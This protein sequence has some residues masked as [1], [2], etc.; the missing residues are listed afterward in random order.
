LGR[1][2]IVTA[3]LGAT[4][5]ALA[6]VAMS[7]ASI[8]SA[9]LRSPEK[10]TTVSSGPG[11]S[12]LEVS[13]TV[14]PD[15]NDSWRS[16]RYTYDGNTV[17]V[18]TD[19]N[20]DGTNT[21]TFTL[22][23]GEYPASSDINLTAFEDEGC[24]GENVGENGSLKFDV[25]QPS[26]NP[27][28]V[29]S[30]GINVVLV[31]DE[32]GSIQQAGA[33]QNVRDAAKAFAQGLVG[34]G[35]SLAL[36]EFSTSAST[37]I[38]LTLVTQAWVDG[39]LTTHLNANYNPAGRTNW[40]A[41]LTQANTVA[42]ASLVVFITD[43]NPNEVTPDDGDYPDGDVIV[44][45]KANDAAS[46]LKAGKHLFAVGVGNALSQSNARVR[47][48]AVSGP[49]EWTS[50]SINDKD[51]TF[52]TSFSDLANELRKVAEASCDVQVT[53][54]KKTD[55]D[56][57][58][59]FESNGGAGWVYDDQVSVTGGFTMKTDQ[60][61]TDGNGQGK[62][63]WRPTVNGNPSSIQ[64][65]ETVK[66]GYQF[67]GVTCS[68]GSPQVDLANKR[69]TLT[70]LNAGASVTCDVNNRR[71]RGRIELRKVWSGT[72]G[73]A[74]LKIGTSAGGSQVDSQATPPLTTG[75]N[76]VA[77]GTYY[78]SEDYDAALY[79]QALACFVDTSGNGVQDGQESTRTTGAGGSV[80]VADGEDVVCTFTN[81]RKQGTLEIRKDFVGS[82]ANRQVVLQL[83]G[84]TKATLSDD[85]T[86]ASL[87]VDTGLK[88]VAEVFTTPADGDLYSS[89]YSCTK[90]G[91][92]YIASAQGRS[93]QVSVGQSET[94]VCT[95]VNTRKTV[96]VTVE[97]DWVGTAT[98]VEL[99]VGG[100]K[101]TVSAEP[102]TH[103]VAIEAG[104]STTVGETAVPANYDAFI[105]CGA[106]A[107]AP[108]TGAKALTNVAASVTC[109]VTNKQQ[110]QV[111][112]TKDLEP[113]SDTGR[114]D[115][116]IGGVTRSEDAGDG[117]TTGFVY[118]SPTGSLTV[119]EIAGDGSTDLARYAATIACDSGKGGSQTTTHTFAVGYGDKVSCVVTN[120]RKTGQV[121]VNKVWLPEAA[122]GSVTLKIGSFTQAFGAGDTQSF[123]KSLNTG[124]TVNVGEAAV[125]A[126]FDAFVD[127][128]GDQVGE[129][130][131]SSLDVTVGET[132]VT[133]TVTNKRKPQVKVTKQLNPTTDPGTFDLQVNG[134][135]KKS[136]ASHGGTTGFVTVPVGNVSVGELAGTGIS[137]G[138]YG[139][140][141]AC[142]SKGDGAAGAT[143]H[144]FAVGY[145]DQVECTI[146]NT[147]KTGTLEVVK[148]YR[149][150]EG[151]QAPTPYSSV[152]LKVDGTTKATAPAQST[153]GPV[154]VNTGQHAASEAFVQAGDADLYTSSGVCKL[155]EQVLGSV[156]GDGRSVTG[157]P[158]GKND[159][160][161]C[162]F[163]NTRKA[164][165]IEVTKAVSETVNGTF[166]TSATKPEPG[167]TFYFRVTI[168]NTSAAD[169]VTI[170]GL[171]D[172]VDG[173]GKVTV[174]D[175]VC[176][177]GDGTFPF[178]LDPG[179]SVVCSFTRNVVGDPRTETDHVE[180]AWKDEDGQTQ[181][182]GPSND[183]T[184]T[185]TNAA[186]AIAVDKVVTGAS[187]LQTPGGSF[188]YRVT[189]TNQSLVED[190]TITSLADFVDTDGALNGAGTP[191]ASIT[192]NG[193]DCAVPFVIAKGGSKVCTFTATV[194]GSPGTYLDVVVVGGAD[195]EGTKTT[196]DDDASVTLTPTPPPPPPPPSSTPEIDVQ[197]VKDAT[198]QVQLGQ[199]GK[200]TITYSALV[201]NNG[202]NMANDVQFAD[203][204]PS[205]VTFGAITK[206]PDFGS[207][208]ISAALLT[209]KLGTMGY[210]VQTLITWTA[211]VS[212]TGTVV[213]TATVTG[214]GGVERAPSNNVDDATT[215]VV[216]P[217]TPPKPKPTP[218][219]KP[220]PVVKPAVCAVLKVTPRLLKASG[221]RQVFQAIVRA[222]D[223]AV[224]GARVQIAG[225]KLRLAARTNAKG[226]ATIVI[227][228][229]VAGL[230]QVRI[231][232]KKACNTQRIGVI[233]VFEPPV[234]G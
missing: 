82:G 165:S 166:D 127:C 25:V 50:G 176:D 39:A 161:V 168:E 146:T 129:V 14:N 104:S 126:G 26:T 64:I 180:A 172:L 160:V 60:G 67:M 93:V 155:G 72:A 69:F 181:D 225:P 83:D 147:R 132:S 13:V 140:Q 175:L 16:T 96:N 88:T 109:V 221:D 217:V 162:T 202:P 118:V 229:G 188:S 11:G 102:A 204:A 30:C 73:A 164:R 48:R 170:T 31:L 47:L 22:T 207:C 66:P 212:V 9:Q 5:A 111:K 114:F 133:C 177:V 8:T 121:T 34:T 37:T 46:A 85:G 3:L 163:T 205:G 117:G 10:D 87:T 74:T 131:G 137:L 187:S 148:V 98:P 42:G 105:R 113:A 213:N 222:G 23:A 97:K 99:F 156:A 94:V 100:S 169:T 231:T 128:T 61:T 233:G 110:P 136:A 134:E 159:A 58:G 57:N 12:L 108:Y 149:T 7:T 173:L 68:A 208:Q 145:G 112:V 201:R 6:L 199:D 119:G 79:G 198:P 89:T 90:N 27:D 218:K 179:E 234:T 230:I 41:A 135:T 124:S 55:E 84:A 62:W 75:E 174:D 190:V 54:T 197:V 53:L 107:D 191:G 171:D 106:E 29:N 153:T 143:S 32:T 101:K 139:T 2:R 1:R 21:E 167:G 195:N 81:T 182:K 192:T 18:D 200:A 150:P 70:G 228:P 19:N 144:S 95:F 33:T 59:S 65:T 17:C 157:I 196:A 38:G 219:P 123:S 223:K 92:S 152:A 185:I 20:G 184:V 211:T 194:N 51:H 49:D 71:L 214:T 63:V 154:Q 215:L 193:L 86:T 78:V 216:A 142:G 186:P 141:I 35:S 76:A 183:A 122:K 115:L 178:Q 206:Q 232:N 116:R 56:A 52:V 203:P 4:L 151:Q 80:A 189:V 120:T 15:N 77:P 125:P 227:R 130:A 209:C 43:G 210:G 28:L 226:V 138:D 220:R 224:S 45:Q 36:V 44:M 40:Q 158:V 24:S 103:T 91:Q